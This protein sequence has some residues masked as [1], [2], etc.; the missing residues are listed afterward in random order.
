[1]SFSTSF[2]MSRKIFF[3]PKILGI[4][5]QSHRDFDKGAA[6]QAPQT[7]RNVSETFPEK[8]QRG[9]RNVSRNKHN[10][11]KGTFQIYL[12]RP[13]QYSKQFALLKLMFLVHFERKF[14]GLSEQM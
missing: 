6:A 2:R 1:M 4:S 12:E 8:F 14:M 9:F 13:I 3:S 7:A 11:K 10:Q 5:N